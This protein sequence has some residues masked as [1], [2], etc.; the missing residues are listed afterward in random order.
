MKFNPITEEHISGYLE[1]VSRVKDIITPYLGGIN[2][3]FSIGKKSSLD[4]L[5][6]IKHY[7]T[8]VQEE[9]NYY[10]SHEPFETFLEKISIEKIDN[11]EENFPSRISEWTCDEALASLNGK[12]GYALSW[13]L[14]KFLLIP[15]FKNQQVQVFKLLPDWGEWPW[16][17]TM[18][19]DFIFETEDN[20]YVM[21]FEETT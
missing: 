18:S 9:A 19:E 4:T 21:Q 11:W 1:A 20:M 10:R 2:K 6:N 3:F 8:K 14:V 16:G 5:T 15:F 7:I 12:H 17:S 13:Y